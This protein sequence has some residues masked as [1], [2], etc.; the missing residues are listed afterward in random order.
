[1]TDSFTSE[2]K[3]QRLAGL[4]PGNHHQL[5]ATVTHSQ[6]TTP[7]HP[8]QLQVGRDP[9]FESLASRAPCVN[10]GEFGRALRE[11]GFAGE[12]LGRADIDT[13]FSELVS[14]ARLWANVS[15]TRAVV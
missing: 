5:S 11:L 15:S 9:T 14:A 10:R 4:P 8:L 2:R 3:H 12:L 13:L 6:A 7:L 1:M